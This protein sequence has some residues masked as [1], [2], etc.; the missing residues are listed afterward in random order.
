MGYENGG[1]ASFG[2][3]VARNCLDLS[4]RQFALFQPLAGYE[5]GSII[6]EAQGPAVNR[7]LGSCRLHI[8]RRQYLRTRGKRA[9]SN[10]QYFRSQAGIH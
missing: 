3:A 1:I 6:A 5:Y 4:P 9:L 8:R 10:R 2:R 7:E